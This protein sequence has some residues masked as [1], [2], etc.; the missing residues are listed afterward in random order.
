MNAQRTALKSGGFAA[1][2]RRL[3]RFTNHPYPSL[4]RRGIASFSIHSH[5]DRSTVVSISLL[6]ATSRPQ[7]PKINEGAAA[8]KWGTRWFI[9]RGAHVHHKRVGRD[10]RAF[11]SG[12]RRD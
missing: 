11:G 10:R 3:R 8:N 7:K 2:I 6:H 12:T 1:S 5:L 9:H 4:K